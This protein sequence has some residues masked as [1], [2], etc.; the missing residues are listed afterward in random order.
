MTPQYYRDTFSWHLPVDLPILQRGQAGEGGNFKTHFYQHLFEKARPLCKCGELLSFVKWSTLFGPLLV[1]KVHEIDTLAPWL[2]ASTAQA[3][4]IPTEAPVIQ[5]T[6]PFREP[7]FGKHTFEH[8][9]IKVVQ[10]SSHKHK[11]QA[12]FNYH[13]FPGAN[14]TK[15]FFLVNKEFFRFSL[16][17]LAVVQ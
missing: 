2:A 8:F 10:Q 9:E 6:W 13:T 12:I 11:F 16:L 14:P 5:T 3:A 15:L 4:P 1:I 17:S 7:V